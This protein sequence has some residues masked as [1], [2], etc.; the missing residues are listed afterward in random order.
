MPKTKPYTEFEL[1]Q[2]I[3][4]I[5]KGLLQKQASREYGIPRSTLQQHLAG[6]ESHQTAYQYQ[7]KLS[8]T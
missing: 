6:R 2:A 3:E 1:A 5:G 8:F 4:A 7:Q